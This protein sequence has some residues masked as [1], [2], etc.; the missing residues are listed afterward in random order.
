MAD[1]ID[2]IPGDSAGAGSI[3]PEGCCPCC[4]GPCFDNC[5]LCDK[6]D[7]VDPPTCCT[8][9][10]CTCF[11]GSHEVVKEIEK[12]KSAWP[13]A[14]PEWPGFSK[15]ELEASFFLTDCYYNDNDGNE[16]LNSNCN[17]YLG[18]ITLCGTDTIEYVKDDTPEQAL[19]VGGIPALCIR[20]T[21][22]T[23]PFAG[24]YTGQDCTKQICSQKNRK[25]EPGVGG[26]PIYEIWCGAGRIC[27][28]EQQPRGTNI[29]HDK[30]APKKYGACI[31]DKNECAENTTYPPKP[32]PYCGNK[33]DPDVE[34]VPVGQFVEMSICCCKGNN[35]PIGEHANPDCN[36]GVGDGGLYYNCDKI[37]EELAEE[38]PPVKIDQVC[39]CA[40]YTVDFKFHDVTTYPFLSTKNPPGTDKCSVA[41]YG[42]GPTPPSSACSVSS[43]PRAG[44]PTD[45]KCPMEITDCRCMDVSEDH[46]G[47]DADPDREWLN[48]TGAD[49]WYICAEYINVQG[50]ACMCCPGDPDQT[51]T[52]FPYQQFRGGCKAGGG[53]TISK[54]RVFI[55]VKEDSRARHNPRGSKGIPDEMPSTYCP[56]CS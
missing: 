6:D 18:S 35:D 12:G 30:T 9:R 50:M 31:W 49:G 2:F 44:C 4:G 56:T 32:A 34:N 39:S 24:G 17:G 14:T 48:A 51:G 19:V 47:L 22:G 16:V 46:P 33:D 15:I 23:S 10:C 29:G 13:Y 53:D 38:P 52:Y 21:D 1:K 7:P 11:P 27:Y 28:P 36:R 54:I 8:G 55:T 45:S 43:T 3:N 41:V 5:E 37:K 26:M 20:K 25:G 42:P 40:C